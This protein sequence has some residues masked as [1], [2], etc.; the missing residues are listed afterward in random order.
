MRRK[1][2]QRKSPYAKSYVDTSDKKAIKKLNKR[3]Y[4]LG[5]ALGVACEKMV[6][7]FA[8]LS[9]ALSKLQLLDLSDVGLEE[10]NEP[11]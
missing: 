9:E 6:T 7:E 3:L 1:G 2:L 11:D 4:G 5:I 8:K 10:P